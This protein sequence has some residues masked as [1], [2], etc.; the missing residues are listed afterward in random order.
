MKGTYAYRRSRAGQLPGSPA[1]PVR[2]SRGESFPSLSEAERKTKVK[3]NCIR[4]ALDTGG[5]AGG[6]YW[7]DDGA[8]LIDEIM[9][10]AGGVVLACKA[11]KRRHIADAI[12]LARRAFGLW[13]LQ[14]R[15][16]DAP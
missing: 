2:T 12:G 1:R 4:R 16:S 3:Q 15:E 7:I 8:D 13:E 11:G 10:M 5:M 9:A 14:L 6:R